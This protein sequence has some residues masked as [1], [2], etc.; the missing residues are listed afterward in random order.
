M[1][2]DFYACD[3][4]GE[5]FADCGDYVSCECGG[6]FCSNDCA[7]MDYGLY[8]DDGEDIGDGPGTCVLCREEEATDIDL[9]SFLLNRCKLTREEAVSLMYEGKNNSENDA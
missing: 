2:V 4:C 3:I 1:G 8:D 6:R 5:V 9:I 7:H